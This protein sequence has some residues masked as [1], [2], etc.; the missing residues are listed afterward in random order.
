[1]LDILGPAYGSC[2]GLRR[3]DF[4]RVGALGLGALTL[5]GLLRARAEGARSGKSPSSKAV[6]QVVLSGGPSHLETYDPKPDA[7][8]GYRTD[9]KAASTCLPGVGLG[10]LMPRHARALD[11]MAVVRSLTHETAD[12]F[13]GLHG[14]LTGFPG[15]PGQQGRNER[16][17]VGSVVARM[18]GANGPGVPPYVAM[19]GGAVF[20]GVFLGGAYLGPGVNPFAIPDDPTGPIRPRDLQ[21]PAGLTLDRLDDRKA[22]LAKLDRIDRRRDQSGTMDG[23]D[24]FAAQAHEIVTGPDARRALD[25][26]REDPKVRDRY[27]R[28][29]IGQG[30]LLAR[31]LVEAGVTFVTV[32]DGN[33]DHHADLATRCRRQVPAMD[34]A[35]ASLVEDLADRG[36]ADE[37]LVVVWGEFGR[38]PRVNGSGGRDH[39]PGSMAAMLAGGG[40]K[41]GQVVGATDRK[42]ERPSERALHPEDVIR[43]IYHVL[44][45]DPLHEFPN[46][47]GRPMAILNRG[48]PIAELI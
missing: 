41:M 36:M 6:I 3:R 14:I 16:P 40:L 22:L 17:S 38:T 34:A 28:T 19:S 24:R 21:P 39:W 9:L 37:V 20:G 31:R 45:L 10:E 25:L 12:H 8:T 42:A 27:G 1:M 44:G 23:L 48:R 30:C 26:A 4:L 7:P 47:S 33:W 11:K 15:S 35:V 46:E 5:P 29:R 2:D 13:A 43:T 32:A 18:R